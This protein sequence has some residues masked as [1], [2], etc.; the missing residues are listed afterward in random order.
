MPVDTGN[1]RLWRLPADAPEREILVGKVW[2]RTQ[3]SYQAISQAH[4]VAGEMTAVR[5]A[6]VD[7]LERRWPGAKPPA[8]AG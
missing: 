7:E 4:D 5:Q 6:I 1:D 2:Q 8:P 3:V